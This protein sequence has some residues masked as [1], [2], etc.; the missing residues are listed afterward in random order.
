MLDMQRGTTKTYSLEDICPHPFDRSLQM[1]SFPPNFETP[2]YDKYRGKTDPQDH[3]REFC[4]ASMEV[5]HNDIY[6]MR[7]FPNSLEGQTIEWFSKLTPSIKT[8]TA[9]VD[10]FVT[11]YS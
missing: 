10:K 6:L 4:A 2:I 7:L 8:F 9:I 5:S 1:I 3:V 11:H